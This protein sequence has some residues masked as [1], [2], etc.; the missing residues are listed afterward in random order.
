[1]AKTTEGKLQFSKGF[2][3]PKMPNIKLGELFDLLKESTPLKTL[4]AYADENNEYVTL[5]SITSPPTVE[6]VEK[7]EKTL[8][9]SDMKLNKFQKSEF[10][11]QKEKMGIPTTKTAPGVPAPT[12]WVYGIT[13]SSGYTSTT[14]KAVTYA[15]TKKKDHPFKKM[16]IIPGA[17]AMHKWH[18]IANASHIVILPS[19]DG[20]LLI[21]RESK[22][23]GELFELEAEGAMKLM[24]KNFYYDG[25]IVDSYKIVSD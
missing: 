20:R 23:W 7:V 3:P 12:P 15:K 22:L 4:P 19:Y 21:P 6:E 2:S 16:E 13:S 9:F 14:T 10:N 5:P 11:K 25:E 17:P 18:S 8:G 1:M 24:S